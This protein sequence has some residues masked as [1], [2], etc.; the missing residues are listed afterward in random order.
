MAVPGIKSWRI[1]GA[2]QLPGIILQFLRM[3]IGFGT[4]SQQCSDVHQNL[5]TDVASRTG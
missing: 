5:E 4:L 2:I 1:F 3:R